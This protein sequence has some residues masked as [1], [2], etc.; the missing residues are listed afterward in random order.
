AFLDKGMLTPEEFVR[1]GDKLIQA[2]PS[3]RWESGD[4]TKIRSYLPPNKQFLAT[5]GVPAY[6]RVN[7]LNVTEIIEDIEKTEGEDKELEV[8]GK[9][10]SFVEIEG[11][12]ISDE[13]ATIKDAPNHT[14]STKEATSGELDK[15]SGKIDGLDLEEEG[16]ALDEA[17]AVLD[18][19]GVAG[20]K[21]ARRY[22]ISM[23]YDNYYRTPRIWMY[24]FDENGTVLTP[25]AVFEDVMQDY[26]KRTVT[27]DPHPHIN[28]AHG[29]MSKSLRRV[30]YF[31][32]LT[33]VCCYCFLCSVDSSVP[34]CP[35]HVDHHQSAAGG[36]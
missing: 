26:A 7:S 15:V 12:S 30:I 32:L 33:Y 9:G 21:R 4:K 27:I 17:T 24:G 25:E 11:Q 2:C 3:W 35:S 34:A 20:L 13:W 5:Y 36:W 10:D 28:S 6:Q 31:C 1:A 18:G 8:D 16:L 14:T 22:N 19:A 29:K 23:T